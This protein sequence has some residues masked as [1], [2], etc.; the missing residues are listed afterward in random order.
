MIKLAGGE[1]FM[2]MF[3]RVDV[4]RECGEWTHFYRAAIACSL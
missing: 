1:S 3:G 2:I 4:V